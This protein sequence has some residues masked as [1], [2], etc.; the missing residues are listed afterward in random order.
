MREV[1]VKFAVRDGAYTA[2]EVFGSGPVDL[3]VSTSPTCPID[4]MWDLPQLAQFMDALGQMA[5]VIAFDHFGYGASD[6]FPII[7]PDA[8][9]ES[10]A[11]AVLSV[12]DAAGSERA[13]LM[14]FL[15]GYDVVV[16]ASYPQRIQ[17]L[18]VC[19]LRSS[20]PELRGLTKEQRKAIA[21]WLA[22]ARGLEY[23]N[24]RV[25]HDPAL[26]R[27][28]GLAH[29]MGA[30]PEQVADTIEFAATFDLGS[31]IEQVR[32]PTLVFHRAGNRMF[33]IETSRSTA[34]RLPNSR[35]VELPG[36]ENDL[37][38]GDTEQVLAEI[39]RF[40]REPDLRPEGDQRHLATVLFTDIV[41]ST[42]RLSALG[43]KAWRELLDDHDRT[44]AQTVASFGGRVVKTLGDG[45]LA[46]FDGPARA[47]RSAVAI[48]DLL[49]AHGVTVRAG[50]H[51]GE[52]ELRGDDVAGVAV[53]IGAR[54]SALAGAGEVLVS[55]T[56]RDLVAGS[57]I[58]FADR[59]EHDLKGVPGNWHLYS[60][61][62]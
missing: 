53:H 61:N 15:G 4:L 13:T 12:M 41:E 52:V 50:L 10:Q 29:R 48:R 33:D 59:G 39:S 49:A 36:S 30:S 3:L 6:P 8:R 5:R 38:L 60:T 37:F 62:A 55:S 26:R 24:P 40:L 44:V 43:D 47:V 25:A 27:W 54:V 23:Y 31:F 57:G 14:A 32:T 46:T 28:W 35:F 51:A 11:S 16:A 21:V 19:N 22:S 58:E 45:M 2:Y 18:V 1:E 17:S 42:E 34:A 7:D 20:H 56:V 9:L